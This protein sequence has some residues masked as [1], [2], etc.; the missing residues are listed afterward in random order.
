MKQTFFRNVF[1]V[2]IVFAL[3]AGAFSDITVY[4]LHLPSF[5]SPNIDTALADSQQ[6]FRITE[7]FLDDDGSADFTGTTYT[8]TLGQ[9]LVANYFVMV[10]GSDGAGTG[11][12]GN[13]G[14]DENYM[15]LVGD[16][17]GT[18]DL[19]TSG[20]TDEL[21]FSRDNNN[22]EW[23]GV[24]TVV[25][26]LL[27]CT[28]S[29]FQL[30]DVVNLT[31][32]GNSISG[33]DTTGVAWT[34]L[35]K[36]MLM[37]GFNGA[38][39][40]TVASQTGRHNS[41]WVKYIPS[42]TNT[43]SWTRDNTSIAVQGAVSTV[44][45][46]Q[47]GAAWGVQRVN[48]AGNNGGNGIN[49]AG[50]YDTVA[51]TSVARANT[52]VW[53]TGTS[54]DNGV[55]DGSE[56]V[57][58]TLGNGV[59]QNANESTVAVGS[60]FT[61]DKDFQVY[62]LTHPDLAVD[63][64][65][66]ADGNNAS[67]TIDQTVDSATSPRMALSFNTSGT[68]VNSFPRPIF[69]ARYTSATNIRLERRR[70]GDTLAAWIQG[71]D[72]SQ[73][74]SPEYTQSNWRMYTTAASTNVGTPLAAQNT[75]PLLTSIGQTFRLRLLIGV[76]ESSVPIGLENFKLQYAVRSGT[77][78]T[79]F[80]G[81][82]YAD[83]TGATP[84]AY[85]NGT[86]A[87]GDNLTANANDPTSANTIINQDY[88]EANNF[89][90]TVATIAAG[91]DGL[92]DFSLQDT[93]DFGEYYCLR[94]VEADGTLL[95]NYSQIPEVTTAGYLSVDIVDSGG[96]T[97]ASPVVQFTPIS[98]DFA[99]QTTTG[100]LGISAERIRVTNTTVNPQWSLTIAATSGNTTLWDSTS[101]DFDYND[102]T[103]SAGDGGDT[104]S[105]GGQLTIDP[106]GGTIT[107]EGGCTTTGVSL[108][109]S[110]AF[111]EAV[112]DSITLSSSTGSADTNCFWDFTD[113]DMSQTIPLEQP[114]AS[115]YNI[116][117][118]LTIVAV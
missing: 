10:R 3:I 6:T 78:D 105:V 117:M 40:E 106:S 83:V 54:E 91:Q 43:I 60:E 115:D 25:E 16:P 114:A 1:F 19:A 111:S 71:I 64:R 107:P 34:N 94:V 35:S 45:A 75:P 29:G 72:F 14:P 53:G 41:C 33:S 26:C 44:M 11:T 93:T 42:S 51:I 32:T 118:T 7:Y 50:E 74:Q 97:V 113:L 52:W 46:V 63:Y 82:T 101:T 92:W 61:D 13:R 31:H 109:S 62:A 56:G 99:D 8:L 59:T 27:D 100:I 17:F 55:G 65:F 18:G 39:C 4:N 58:V 81:E 22:N 79:S 57:V 86:P 88:E 70:S 30:I 80:T 38:G 85:F 116:D 20:A 77:C 102:P 67:L 47:W 103:A 104:D 66:L 12:G 48:L 96:S 28:N 37:G 36:V 21:D 2:F 110:G 24:V 90:N 87:D 95:D 76:T 49:S 112:I 69:S 5:Y 15:R 68:T 9:D 84:I 73:I 23:Y 108:G 89:T 98:F